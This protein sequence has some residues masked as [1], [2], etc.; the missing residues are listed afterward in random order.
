M[1]GV[2]RVSNLAHYAGIVKESARL[3]SLIHTG[4]TIQQQAFNA[5]GTADEISARAAETIA[6]LR[7]NSGSWRDV[8]H[9]FSDFEDAPSLSFAIKG[10]LQNNGATLIG[11][12]SGHG[13]NLLMLSIVKALLSGE[14]APS[15]GT[16]SR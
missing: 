14:R 1:D 16:A 5:E 10:F 2:P 8:F 4:H 6:A 12:L 11:G 9:S 3:R 7:T 13:K 15:F